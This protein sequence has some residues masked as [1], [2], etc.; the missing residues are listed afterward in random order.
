MSKNSFFKRFTQWEYWPSYMFYLPNIPYAF[1]LAL[2]TGNFT[3]YSIVNP[4]IKSSGNG[5]E[6][7]FKTLELIPETYK[8]KSIYVSEQRNFE[9][10]LK[11]LHKA[12]ID[13]PVIAKPDVGFRGM[14]V[15]KIKHDRELKEYLTKYPI[16]LI[17]QEFIDLPNECGVFY[18]RKPGTEKGNINSLT[19]KNFL[20]VE[21][22]GISTLE[23]LV[24]FSSRAKHYKRKLAE[25]HQDRWHKIIPK[26]ERIILSDIGNHSQG[27]QF[28]NANHLI[29]NQLI[30]SFD[31]INKE[32]NGWYYGRLDIKYEDWEQLQIGQDLKILEINGI[33]AEPT[34]IYDSYHMTYLGALKTIRSHWRIAA[35]IAK[36][37]MKMGVK[38]KKFL[39]FWKEI[40]WLTDYVKKIKVLNKV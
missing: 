35:E 19:F 15:K 9:D 10:I 18:Y 40:L 34:H 38:P 17:I 33:L 8:P 7:K 26:G 31:Q 4:S 5:T 11:A 2:R 14:L 37:Q 24:S 30:H 3:F 25:N 29:N 22:N 1:Y 36:E 21:G 27:T 20:N 23:E 13:Y 12:G 39:V 16:P 32:I 28:I 6:S